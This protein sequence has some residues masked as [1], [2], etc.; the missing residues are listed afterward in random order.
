[1]IDSRSKTQVSTKIAKL[2]SMY[3]ISREVDIEITADN[4][5]IIAIIVNQ[6]LYD[7]KAICRVVLVLAGKIYI[8]Q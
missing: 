5:T 2:Y 4:D 7:K 6:S 3:P 1:M 8:D